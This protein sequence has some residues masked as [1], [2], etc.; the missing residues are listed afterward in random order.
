MII[1]L[2]TV[3]CWKVLVMM[4]VVMLN[5]SGKELLVGLPL[6]SQG[7][8]LSS[9]QATSTARLVPSWSRIYHPDSLQITQPAFLKPLYF[10]VPKTSPSP[11]VGRS[12]LFREV[13]P[14]PWNMVSCWK[15]MSPT[16]LVDVFQST[17]TPLITYCWAPIVVYHL[18]WSF[19]PH[20]ND[21]LWIT[22][23]SKW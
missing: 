19:Y 16:P 18:W 6:S 13:K 2:L 4:F 1:I 20:Q 5:V 21:K 7:K 10:E 17:I 12:W 3:T 15:I 11:L 22:Y 23:K 8:C 9:P 14:M